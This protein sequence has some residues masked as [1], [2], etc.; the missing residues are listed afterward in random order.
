MFQPDPVT[1]TVVMVEATLGER[2]TLGPPVTVKVLYADGGGPP[3]LFAV[4][5]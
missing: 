1:V 4:T 5:M 2:V 3:T